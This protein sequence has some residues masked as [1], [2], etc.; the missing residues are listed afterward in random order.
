MTLKEI[1]KGTYWVGAIDWDRTLFDALIPLPDGTSYNAY[2]VRGSEKTVL[3]DTVDPSMIDVLMSHLDGVE[4]VDLIVSQHAEQDH[5]GSIP[6]VLERYP[7]A[8]VVTTPK[9]KGMLTGLMPIPDERIMTVEDGETLSLGDKTLQFIHMP[10]VH[11]PETML[12]YLQEDRILFTCDL[13]GSHVATDDLYAVEEE[14]VYEAARRY[15]AEI[16]MPLRSM[17]LRNLPK[18]EAIDA[19]VIA[20]SHGPLYHKPQPIVD[21]YRRWLSGESRNVVVLPYVS[22]HGST[23]EMIAYFVEALTGRGV[24]VEAFDLTR[25]DIGHLTATLVDAPTVVFGTPTVLGGPH[26]NVMSGAYLI[27]TLK[28]PVQFVSVIA[29][30]GWGGKPVERLEEVISGLKAEML[31]PV[32]CKGAPKAADFGAL[33]ALAAAIAAKHQERNLM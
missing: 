10:W 8:S 20:P 12:T 14:R 4:Q 13:F 17:I 5:S 15:Y 3:V 16:M 9:G 24:A 23:E 19:A 22:M 27:N 18:V 2:L 26:P 29:S 32:L 1:T 21:A 6:M 28:P 25:S 7:A 33:D 31:S 11:W 30:Y